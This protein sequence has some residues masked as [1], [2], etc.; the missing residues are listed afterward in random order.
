[1]GLRGL[2]LEV[3]SLQLPDQR[4]DLLGF[5]ES[6]FVLQVAEAIE[7]TLAPSIQLLV[8][9]V[10]RAG[11][12]FVEGLGFLFEPLIEFMQVDVRENGRYRASLRSAAVKCGGKPSLRGIRPAGKSE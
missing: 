7:R 6:A 3:L 9:R 4:F 5:I 2:A 12:S 8:F 1:M 10:G 11:R